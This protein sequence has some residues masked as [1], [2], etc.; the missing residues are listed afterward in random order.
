LDDFN[1]GSVNSIA[2]AALFALKTN[3]TFAQVYKITVAFYRILDTD[4]LQRVKRGLIGIAQSVRQALVLRC[5][6]CFLPTWLGRSLH[7]ARLA[8]ALL[9][10]WPVIREWLFFFQTD[11]VYK[12]SVELNI[13]IIA[14]RAIIEFMALCTEHP[15]LHDLLSI[16]ISYPGIISMLFG[17]WDLETKNP[18][19][20]NRAP[21][22]DAP[23]LPPL[24]PASAVL[25]S[26]MCS[27]SGGESWNWREIMRPFNDD[28]AKI[29]A[30]ALDHLEQ[31]L[32][33]DPINYNAIIWDTHLLTNL[34]VHK[35]IRIPLLMQHSMQKVTGAIVVLVSQR[36]PAKQRPLVAR[37][38]SYACWY[39]RSYVEDTDG[40][41]WINEVVEAGLLPALLEVEPWLRHLEDVNEEDWTP[42]W[43]LLSNI[44]PKYTIFRSV[45]KVMGRSVAAIEAT[46][47][48]DRLK[49]DG[50]LYK[51]WATLESLVTLRLNLLEADDVDETHVDSCQSS[52][53]RNTSCIPHIECQ[54][55]FFS[56]VV[57]LDQ[58]APSSAV[59]AAF[60]CITAAKNARPTTGNKEVIKRI[61]AEYK[62]AGPVRGFKFGTDTKFHSFLS[63]KELCPV[64]L[65]VTSVFWI[66][67]S[68]LICRVTASESP[69]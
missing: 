59:R 55:R 41:P 48:V 18:L 68:R 56:S 40:L 19:F 60:T 20:G 1:K 43:V 31:D 54:Y 63:Q 51:H 39:I 65:L 11:C 16:V 32:A 42:I 4:H 8:K 13:R 58:Q 61:V 10:H 30:T 27:F 67:S 34:S 6:A 28:P 7:S 47:I 35:D 33:H 62:L 14:K 12:E 5:L 38:I 29:A 46:E 25:D 69:K 44:L 23:G 52:K 2:Q 37:A 36:P 9:A 22:D 17:L 66:A 57:S 3:C 26:C 50:P 24:S 45:L 21:D 53:A 15:K 49:T 64:F